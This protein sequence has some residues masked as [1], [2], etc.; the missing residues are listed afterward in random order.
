MF[1]TKRCRHGGQCVC[2]PECLLTAFLCLEYLA[3][4]WRPRGPTCQAM[5]LHSSSMSPLKP[6]LV[7]VG[8]PQ[9]LPPLVLRLRFVEL[10]G[11]R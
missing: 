4:G 1:N 11:K 7:R 6:L 8:L 3:I 10:R 5:L 2:R 9:G